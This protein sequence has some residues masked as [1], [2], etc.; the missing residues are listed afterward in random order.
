MTR[1]PLQFVNQQLTRCSAAAAAVVMLLLAHVGCAAATAGTPRPKQE[2]GSRTFLVHDKPFLILG[3]E[4]GNSPG[5]A[6]D[7]FLPRLAAQHSSTG[8]AGYPRR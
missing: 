7:T 2:G 3:G 8:S 1:D 6:A 4:L 5:T